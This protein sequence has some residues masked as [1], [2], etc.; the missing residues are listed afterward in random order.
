VTATFP[1]PTSEALVNSKQASDLTNMEQ[2]FRYWMP[3]YF[4]HLKDEKRK[5]VY[6]PVNRDYKPLGIVSMKHVDYDDFRDQAMV[7]SSD[8]T[9]LNDVW[10]PGRQPL[11]LYNDDPESRRDYFVRFEKLLSRSIKLATKP[12]RY[13]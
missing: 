6:L 4:E 3:Y 7:F 5:H 9:L 2:W 12:K 1:G 8:P 10:V 11:F 13:G